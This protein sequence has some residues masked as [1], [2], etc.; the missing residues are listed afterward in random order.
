MLGLLWNRCA[1][2]GTGAI[3]QE[4]H[5]SSP[6][7]QDKIQPLPIQRQKRKSK[8]NTTRLSTASNLLLSFL[9]HTTGKEAQAIVPLHTS[10]NR[11]DLQDPHFYKH[12]NDPIRTYL[13]T[14]VD[15]ATK[16][17]ARRE[18]FDEIGFFFG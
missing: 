10:G 17:G 18:L 16:K 12:Q 11:S 13:F 3:S 14:F 2:Y 15:C 6:E 1:R 9:E 7:K 8:Q 4:A 5:A